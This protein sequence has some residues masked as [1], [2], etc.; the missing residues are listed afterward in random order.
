MAPERKSFI[1]VDE[2]MPKV[3]L[4]QVAAYYGVQIPELHRVGA[5]TRT[6]CF[7]NCGRTCE[8][9]DRVLAIQ[10]DHPAKQWK[11]HQYECGKGGNLISLCDLMKAGQN[12]AGRPRGDRF[13]EIAAD[14]RAL[15]T[16]ATRPDRKKSTA[17]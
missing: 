5:E 7:L 12:A 8:T 16:G 13:K 6:R 10:A 1:N 4:E 2:L 14:L 11:C 9:G 17:K 3:S 15:T